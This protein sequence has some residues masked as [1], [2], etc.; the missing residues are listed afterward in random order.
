MIPVS[1]A[2]E[3]PHVDNATQ[4]WIAGLVAAAVTLAF[5]AWWETRQHRRRQLDEQLGRLADAHQ[6]FALAMHRM[7]AS[8]WDVLEAGDLADVVSA[9]QLRV[10]AL[11]GRRVLNVPAR[12]LAPGR[13][14][15]RRSLFALNVQW[16]L[17][18]QQRVI[19]PPKRPRTGP[20]G[21]A[22]LKLVTPLYDLSMAQVTVC[23][24]W[25][26]NPWRYVPRRDLS[27]WAKSDDS[28]NDPFT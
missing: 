9:A 4:G 10:A 20:E 23:A 7:A 15:L 6:R 11:A 24:A 1:A 2:W 12:F 18:F 14:G 13:D 26:Q 27:E 19:R 5:T 22:N 3:H 16:T 21:V 28:R 25:M 8:G 17:E